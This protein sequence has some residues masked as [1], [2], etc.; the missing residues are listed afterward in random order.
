MANRMKSINLCKYDKRLSGVSSEK[1]LSVDRWVR[2][3]IGSAWAAA[4]RTEAVILFAIIFHTI[5]HT[6]GAG[7]RSWRTNARAG[8]SSRA[9]DRDGTGRVRAG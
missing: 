8:S 7:V 4:G 5:C 1:L 3:R 6:G 9:R 2:G